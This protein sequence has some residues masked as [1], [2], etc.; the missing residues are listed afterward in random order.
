MSRSAIKNFSHASSLSGKRAK[1]LQEY[2]GTRYA[3]RDWDRHVDYRLAFVNTVRKHLADGGSKEEVASIIWTRS[4]GAEAWV[5]YFLNEHKNQ[6]FGLLE[7]MAI[8]KDDF[9]RTPHIGAMRRGL[10]RLWKKG[11]IERHYNPEKHES[12]FRI[13]E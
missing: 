10:R 1:I 9:G 11:Q 8:I 4:S 5:L 12:K 3:Q 13:R 7:L 6:W 2:F